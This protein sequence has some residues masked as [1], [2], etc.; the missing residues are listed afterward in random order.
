MRAEPT[1]DFLFALHPVGRMG[2][3]S[4][5]VEVVLY[6]ESAPFVTGESLHVVGG[7]SAGH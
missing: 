7:Q 3:I 4:D 2:D 1:H 5:R 6:L